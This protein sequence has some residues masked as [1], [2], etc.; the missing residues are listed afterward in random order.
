M[1][2]QN[3]PQTLAKLETPRLILRKLRLDDAEDMFEYAQD[4]ELG[5][6]GLWLP[7]TLLQESIDDLAEAVEGYAKGNLWDWAIEHRA[8]RKMIGRLGLHGYHKL[9]NRADLGYALNRAYWGQG[10]G[11]EAAQEVIDFGFGV[12]NLHR[13]GASVLADNNGSIKVLTKIGMR[14]EGVKRD[15][16]AI[17][18]KHEDLHSYSILRLEWEAAVQSRK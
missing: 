15:F 3:Y 2:T 5:L 1:T 9:D 4:R 16:T 10:Y 8:E 11:T 14:F 13:I 18:G 12:L 7:Y 6:Q 17:R